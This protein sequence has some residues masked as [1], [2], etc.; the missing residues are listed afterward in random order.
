[1]PYSDKR[2]KI[3]TVGD[4][5]QASLV[6]KYMSAVGHFLKSNDRTHLNPFVGKSVTDIKQKSHRLE[7]GPKTLYRL[8]Q[9]GGSTFEQ[10]YRIVI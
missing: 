10:V 3:V 4:F 9:T 7:T 2:E 5:K 6:G 1:M 8:A